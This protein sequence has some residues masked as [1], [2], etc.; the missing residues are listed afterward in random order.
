MGHELIHGFDNS[1]RQFDKDGLRRQWW[2]PQIIT[3]FVAKTQC[4]INQYS[5]ITV[6]GSRVNGSFTQ[7]EN[8]ADN[9]GIHM[10]F[11]ALQK[12][13]AM[14]AAEGLSDPL[15][16]TDHPLT[17]DQLFYY[18]HAQTWCTVATD[19]HIANQVRTDVHSP[20]QARVWAPLVNQKDFA[21][22]YNC[23]VGSK[24]NPGAASCDLY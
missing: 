7:G 14:L 6:Q 1:G 21:I 4:M 22:A 10:A 5:Q 20:G 16:V 17:T 15:P 19:A 23:P 3:N 8:I 2:D 13:K 12:Y 24:M 11:I 9:G 18:A